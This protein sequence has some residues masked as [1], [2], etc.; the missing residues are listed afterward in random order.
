ML[1]MRMLQGIDAAV[2]CWLQSSCNAVLSASNVLCQLGWPCVAG[3]QLIP[4]VP[5]DVRGCDLHLQLWPRKNAGQPA[6]RR[7][8]R[9][10]GEPVLLPTCRRAHVQ[11]CAAIVTAQ[12][13]AQHGCCL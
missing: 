12:L 3:G 6:G 10:L 13:S 4:A 7:R 9:P 8:L 11:H 2:K 1:R 5:G